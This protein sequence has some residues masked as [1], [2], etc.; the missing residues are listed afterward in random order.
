[1]NNGGFFMTFKGKID[2][3]RLLFLFLI[4]EEAGLA[5]TAGHAV[6]AA[7]AQCR[8]GL[9]TSRQILHRHGARSA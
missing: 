4:N 1:M 6:V 5:R 7:D 8:F 2:I 3:S 9:R